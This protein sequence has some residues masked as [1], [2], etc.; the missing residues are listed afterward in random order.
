MKLKFKIPFS[1]TK[2]IKYLDI[3]LT[4]YAQSVYAETTHYC[5]KETKEDINKWRHIFEKEREIDNFTITVL[6]CPL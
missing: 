4:K 2:D 6:K 3:S 5:S 1:I